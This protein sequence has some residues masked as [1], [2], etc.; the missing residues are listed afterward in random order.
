[1]GGVKVQEAKKAKQASL[2]RMPNARWF[3][4]LWLPFQ[5]RSENRKPLRHRAIIAANSEVYEMI[6][7]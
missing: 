7:V 6:R 1:M 5:N 3:V 4:A 2:A